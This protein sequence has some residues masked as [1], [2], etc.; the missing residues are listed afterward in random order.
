MIRKC[1]QTFSF[2]VFASRSCEPEINKVKFEPDKQYILLLCSD[3]VWDS[4]TQPGGSQNWTQHLWPQ[5]NVAR[6]AGALLALPLRWFVYFVYV[7]IY[8]CIYIYIY[9]YTGLHPL[10]LSTSL[11]LSL[12]T[13][14]MAASPASPPGWTHPLFCIAPRNLSPRKKSL[15]IKAQASGSWGFHV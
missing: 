9:T 4:W 10:S 14:K 13:A 11:S 2:A 15:G 8:I 12:S 1:H 5:I 3:G 6:V 7:Y